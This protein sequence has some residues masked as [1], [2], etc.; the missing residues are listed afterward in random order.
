MLETFTSAPPEK[1]FLFPEVEMLRIEIEA[2]RIAL[3]LSATIKATM[4]VPILSHRAG[5]LRRAY[6]GHGGEVLALGINNNM[7]VKKD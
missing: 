7:S 3:L 1:L 2:Y 6:E 5:N 4:Q